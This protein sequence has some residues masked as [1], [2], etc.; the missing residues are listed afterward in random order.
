MKF[1]NKTTGEIK[2]FEGILIN[3][4]LLSAQNRQRYYWCN[5]E[6][7]QPED[8]GIV[9]ADILESDHV[10][11]E[12]SHC[13]DANY[14]K[15]GNLKS[16]YEKNRRQLVFDRPCK[17]REFDKSQLLHHVADATDINGHDCL[18]CVY[19]DSE[20]PPT[21]T[22]AGGGNLEPK[23][24]TDSAH[25]RKLT[26]TECEA[27]Q[28]VPRDYTRAS[29]FFQNNET[30]KGIK[31]CGY[32]SSKNA[33]NQSQVGKLN[34]AI[35]TILDSLDTALPKELEGMSIK[36]KFVSVKG[37]N[38][39]SKQLKVSVS[40]IIKNGKEISQLTNQ[41]NAECVISLLGADQKVIAPSIIANYSGTE[42]QL[43]QSKE[44]LNSGLM[45]K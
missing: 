22:A 41:K 7:K 23:V 1:R 15:G 13:I 12:K 5:W 30:S 36:L 35:S 37:A 29:F 19:A 14:F 26:P 43:N 8:K 28:T 32:V 3:S 25:Y 18:K 38:A 16:Y 34:S 39:D 11:R 31:K 2:E 24:T 45:W 27:L 6:V 44:N 9:L 20:K 40:N 42:I 4:A 21:L 33:I 17:L 10:D